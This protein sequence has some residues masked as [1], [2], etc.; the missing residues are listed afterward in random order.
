[1]DDPYQVPC[2]VVTV[3][4]FLNDSL[5]SSFKIRFTDTWILNHCE[6]GQL[7]KYHIGTNDY[8]SLIANL[9]RDYIFD[10]RVEDLNGRTISIESQSDFSRNII[11]ADNGI[12]NYQRDLTIVAKENRFAREIMLRE[13]YGRGPSFLNDIYKK[14]NFYEDTLRYAVE[15]LKDREFIRPG[16]NTLSLTYRGL[17]FVEDRFLLSPFRNRIFLIAACDDLIYKLI[18]EV[19]RPVV[20]EELAKEL[21]VEYE[22]KFQERSEPKNTIHDDIWEHL[23]HSKLILCDLTFQKPNCFIEYG[24]A[25]AKG[26]HIILCVEESEGKTE[27][28]RLKVPFDTQAQKYSFWKKEWLS[29]KDHKSDLIKFK[30]EINERIK[31]KLSIIDASSEL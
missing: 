27:E 14:C 19:Y 4:I 26:K 28:G 2:S 30:D 23:E 18:D 13:L 21:E 29:G 15:A 7:S 16:N 24:Y 9:I 31:M 17:T 11:K 8:S 3:N 12:L 5:V 1:M 6:S 22:L 25:L 20:E 10:K